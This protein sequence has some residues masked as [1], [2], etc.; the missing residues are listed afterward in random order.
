MFDDMAL[1]FTQSYFTYKKENM[2]FITTYND[3]YC[4]LFFVSTNLQMMYLF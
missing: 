2:I 1:N 4:K 3:V